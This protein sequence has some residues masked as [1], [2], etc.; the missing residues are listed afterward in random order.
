M[1]VSRPIHVA[2]NGI[3]SFFLIA[4]YYSI[5]HMYHIIFI[6]SSCQWTL[7]FFLDSS[8][9][10]TTVN[11]AAMNSRVHPFKPC[12]SLDTCPGVELLDHMVVSFLVFVCMFVCF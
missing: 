10:L 8:H 7:F 11:N 12:F 2:V 9:V 5:V 6:H 3:V 1:I 4:E